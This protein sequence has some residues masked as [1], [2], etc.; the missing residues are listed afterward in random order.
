MTFF[1]G[2]FDKHSSRRILPKTFNH[3][4]FETPILISNFSSTALTIQVTSG[5]HSKPVTSG[6]HSK[7]NSDNILNF[8]TDVDPHSF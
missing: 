7:P 6:N 1:M 3:I 8:V 5:N 4:N 2:L